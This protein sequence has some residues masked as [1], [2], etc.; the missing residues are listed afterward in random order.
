LDDEKVNLKWAQAAPSPPLFS[1]LG[2][3]NIY[4]YLVKS[5]PDRPISAESICGDAN[6]GLSVK[7]LLKFYEASIYPEEGRISIF[8]DI[9]FSLLS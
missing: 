6:K 1:K 5:S 3:D 8:S 9:S 2:G 4:L 7:K